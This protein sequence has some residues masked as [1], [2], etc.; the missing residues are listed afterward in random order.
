VITEY[1]LARTSRA[2]F[3][4][5]RRYRYQLRRCFSG[6]IDSPPVNPVVFCMLNPS[7]ADAFVNDPTIRR[8]IGF[9]QDWG[10]T[11]LIV[12]NLFAIR[13]TDSKLLCKHINPVGDDNMEVFADLPRCSIVCAW[14]S[15]PM[16]RARA[17]HVLTV[18]EDDRLFTLRQT[19]GGHPGHPLYLPKSA[20]LTPWRGYR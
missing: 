1:D 8:C 7:T 20:Q 3:S 15:H 17:R 11:D 16:V 9:A 10:H 13:E 5:D 14:G 6:S 2:D 4:D 12:V 19:Q 18:L